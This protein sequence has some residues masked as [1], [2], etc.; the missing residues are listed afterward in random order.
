MWNDRGWG[1]IE[2]GLQF[3]DLALDGEVPLKLA[4]CAERFVI[5]C[6][7]GGAIR[8][9]SSGRRQ[10]NS[11]RFA[12]S[13]INTIRNVPRMPPITEIMIVLVIERT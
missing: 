13:A 8:G 6:G 12:T 9:C 5:A 7:F 11:E 3:G 2:L 1:S 4:L 10:R